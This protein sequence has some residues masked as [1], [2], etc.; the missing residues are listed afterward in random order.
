MRMRDHRPINR[1]P[2]IDKKVAG[3]A[4]EALGAQNKQGGHSAKA[5][6]GTGMPERA[7]RTRF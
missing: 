7:K 1:A 3:L 4:I 5:E 6:V 2:W